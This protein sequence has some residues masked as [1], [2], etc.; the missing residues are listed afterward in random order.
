MNLTS[1]IFQN[2]YLK[3][4]LPILGIPYFIHQFWNIPFRITPRHTVP[5]AG[6]YRTAAPDWMRRRSSDKIF[7]FKS[8]QHPSREFVLSFP[9]P[10]DSIPHS[11]HLAERL[12]ARA[13]QQQQQ[14]IHFSISRAA[15]CRPWNRYV[16]IRYNARQRS[17]QR[18][19]KWK[20]KKIRYLVGKEVNFLKPSVWI[21]T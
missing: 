12:L 9:A 19:P 14:C 5:C 11:T 3:G 8:L 2:F 17:E 1:A 16:I 20:T 6:A 10:A 7:K 18:Q 4:P 13:V 15:H 21:F